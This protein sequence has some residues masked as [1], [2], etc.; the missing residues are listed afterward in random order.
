MKKKVLVTMSTIAMVI[1]GSM[2]AYAGEWKQ[3]NI[4]WRYQNDD[5]SNSANS[6][7]WIDGN[8]DGIAESYY[9]DHNGYLLVNT[10]TPDGYQVNG[11]GAWIK[12]GTVQTKILEITENKESKITEDDIVGL[13]EFIYVEVLEDSFRINNIV[14]DEGNKGAIEYSW[15]ESDYDIVKTIY[16]SKVEEPDIGDMTR[17]A[18]YS[19]SHYHGYWFSYYVVNGP[20][21]TTEM[22]CVYSAT[23]IS[24]ILNE[25]INNVNNGDLMW[26]RLDNIPFDMKY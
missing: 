7:Q 6:W 14:T 26:G 24:K 15:S 10:I 13:I 22:S 11:N 18:V 3:D 16:F 21:N 20:V 19:Y 25:S 1:V 5:G 9:F 23:D 8:N 2:T 12:D 4:G 17:N